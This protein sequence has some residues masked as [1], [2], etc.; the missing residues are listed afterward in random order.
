MPRW[1]G[2]NAMMTLFNCF[3]KQLNNVQSNRK[4][5]CK[6]FYLRLNH[7]LA[8]YFSIHHV[9]ESFWGF[10]QSISTIYVWF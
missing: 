2:I 1:I 10:F 5:Y 7:N 8:F 9:L 6:K 3:A 4:V